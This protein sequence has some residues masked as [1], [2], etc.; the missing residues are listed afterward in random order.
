MTSLQ[1]QSA[2]L[3]GYDVDINHVPR[4]SDSLKG[5]NPGFEP[6]VFWS[7]NVFIAFLILLSVF[8]CCFVQ[9][10]LF[11]G[12]DR[13]LVSDQFYQERQ[14][15][16][17]EAAR[18]ESPE[19]RKEKLQASFAKHRV[20]MTVKKGDLVKGKDGL[21]DDGSITERNCTIIHSASDINDPNECSNNQVDIET[22]SRA[23]S[24]LSLDVE[25]A[26]QLQLN[27]ASKRLVPNCCAICLS[28]YHPGDVVVWSSNPECVH[29][30]HRECVVDWLIK[31]Q[32]ETPCPCCRQEFT[33][34]EEIRKQRKIRWLSTFAFDLSSIQF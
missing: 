10:Y 12:T 9:R 1:P 17:R 3:P 26:G 7:V 28:S 13:M 32:P 16:R 2:E 27:D 18:T 33:D 15:R 5:S 24:S 6:K 31:M 8:W 30:F 21:S 11:N 34:L 23:S 14:R 25:D 4:V 22:G 19:K 29:A 20:Q